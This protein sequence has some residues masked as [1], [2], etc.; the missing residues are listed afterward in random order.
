MHN[1]RRACSLGTVAIV[2]SS[3]IGVFA[4]PSAVAAEC[5]GKNSYNEQVYMGG[6]PGANVSVYTATVEMQDCETQ[7]LYDSLDNRVAATNYLAGFAS[8]AG[9]P[10]KAFAVL[11]LTD[12]AETY[13]QDR[14]LIKDCSDNFS[15]PIRFEI[16]GTHISKCHPQ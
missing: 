11:A 3:V 12:S 10:G 16:H 9:W 5:L 8:M 14:A 6:A 7:R 1:I 15:R 4:S 2:A 13:F